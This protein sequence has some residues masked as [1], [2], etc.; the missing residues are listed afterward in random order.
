MS[1]YFYHI[2]YIDYDDFSIINFYSTTKYS[3]EEFENIIYK[4]YK[5][6]LDYLIAN[7]ENCKCYPNIFINMDTVI[8]EKEFLNIIEEIS[9]L[10]VTGRRETAQIDFENKNN[11]RL[12]DIRKDFILS[13][14]ECE[15]CI[16]PED[17]KDKCQKGCLNT[18]RREI[19][20]GE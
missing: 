17:Y 7:E 19:L 4:A 15:E 9:D 13:L 6:Y 20:L 18:R 1:I 12:M 2:S 14:G 3:P 8:T 16:I 5:L 11:E 10:K